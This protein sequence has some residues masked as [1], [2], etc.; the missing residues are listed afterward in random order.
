MQVL[1]S[2]AKNMDLSRALPGWPSSP[3][4]FEAEARAIA[5]HMCDYEVA[6]LARM[7]ATTPRI[8]ARSLAQYEAFLTDDVGVPAALLYSGMAYRHLKADEFTADDIRHARAHL[9]ITSFLY[10]LNRPTEE[11]RPYRMEGSVPPPDGDARTL[12]DYWPPRL[13]DLL[14]D[15][16]QAD[17]GILVYLASGEMKRLF[18]WKRVCREVRVIVPEFRVA[19]GDKL[20]TVVVYAKMMRGAMARHILVARPKSPEALAGFEY[21]GFALDSAAGGEWLW[22]NAG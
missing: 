21:E 7:L 2:P 9:W 4:R 14:I 1:L 5:R 20:K 17:D 3:A 16:V 12:F 18:D 11:L 13:T 10:G 8:A 22:V 6:E 15:S 19:V